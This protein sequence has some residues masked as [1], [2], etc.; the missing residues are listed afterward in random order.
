MK[1]MKSSLAININ[2]PVN[3]V[4]SIISNGR[5]RTNILKKY[6]Q[7]T[8]AF[9]VQRIPSWISSDM[10]TGIGFFGNIIVFLSF[11]LATFF[12]EKYLL[13]GII[14]FIVSWFG[15]SL[16]GRIAYYR[17]KPR[18]WYGF[19]LDMTIDWIGIIL[20]GL[21][22]IIFA[23][24]ITKFLGY[25]FITLYGWE[26]ITALLRFKITDKYS[27]DSGI[28]GPTEVRIIISFVLIIEVIFK[29]SITYFAAIACLGLLISNI[30]NLNNLLKF[31]DESD[32]LE[33]AMKNN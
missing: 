14:G 31:S 30:Y 23:S 8:I 16:D 18:K 27:I 11:L 22:F 6:E 24:G 3:E 7:I 10:L 32:R 5:Q 25:C 29:G 4:K 13:I 1:N 28:F 19:A 33:H 20:V 2:R 12:G 21:G 26:M 15:D 9:L 17:G